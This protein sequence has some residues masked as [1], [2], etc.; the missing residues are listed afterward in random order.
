VQ[1]LDAVGL[2]PERAPIKALPMPVLQVKQDGQ[3]QEDNST[4]HDALFIHLRGACAAAL[5]P[6]TGSAFS[7]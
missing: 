2:S 3:D 5:G 1:F 7:R 4:G 6:G